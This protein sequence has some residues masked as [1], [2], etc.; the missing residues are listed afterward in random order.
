NAEPD[1][2]PAR[3]GKKG[4]GKETAGCV[5]LG[6]RRKTPAIKSTHNTA[7]RKHAVHGT[8]EYPST[9]LYFTCSL[10]AVPGTVAFSGGGGPV[11]GRGGVRVTFWPGTQGSMAT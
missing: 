6:L 5:P 4:Q 2:N 8:P 11:Y 10:Q 1:S 9:H 7:A 3:K